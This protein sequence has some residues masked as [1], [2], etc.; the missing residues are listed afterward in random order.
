MGVGE[1]DGWRVGAGAAVG[2][3]VGVKV[4]TGPGVGDGTGT[5]AAVG[6]GVA[7]GI[8]VGVGKGVAVGGISERASGIGV[9]TGSVACS[10]RQEVR[11]KTNAKDSNAKVVSQSVRE[12]LLLPVPFDLPVVFVVILGS[13]VLSCPAG[14]GNGSNSRMTGAAASDCRNVPECTLI[15]PAKFT[16][17]ASSILP[18]RN[19]RL[20][21]QSVNR[22]PR[23]SFQCYTVW[24]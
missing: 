12:G 18:A 19:L 8:G 3:A 10:K 17:V 13:S 6:I 21:Y 4:G 24:G 14:P 9:S 5:A 16:L 2:S 1:G 15:Y 22:W 11:S 23:P 20:Y 7:A